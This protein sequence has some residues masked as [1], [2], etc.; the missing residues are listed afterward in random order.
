MN[1]LKISGGMPICGELAVGGAK[2]SSLPLLAATILGAGESVLHNCPALSDVDAACKI[3]SYL[4]C[5]VRRENSTVVVNTENLTHFDVPDELMREMRS[6]IV[7]LGA[8]A[9]RLGKTK[10]SFPGGCDL[11]ARPIDLHLSSLRQLGLQIREEH[12]YLN[13][14]AESRLKGCDISLSFPSVGA[15]ENIMLAAATAQGTTVI[16]N[17]AQEPE[18][19]DLADFLNKCGAKIQNAGKSTIIIEGVDRLSGA[20]HTVIPDRIVATTYL[21]CAAATGGEI[22]VT[23]ADPEAISSVLPV[24]R[25]MGCKILTWD[26]SIY[27]KGKQRLKGA[28]TIRTM[29]Y[30]GFPTDAQALLMAL[31]TR[32][33]GTTVF[34]ENIFENRFK[35]AGELCR[36]GADIKIEGK[37]AVVQGV[38]QLYGASVRATDLRGGA[39]MIIA[40]LAAQGDTTI[41]DVYHIERGYENI[42]ENL[43]KLGANIES[44]S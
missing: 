20:E 28:K 11:G 22:I 37:V 32:A 6:S 9:A 25:E 36:M 5:N 19:I 7:F 17:A 42:C 34:V 41:S 2:N 29:P 23:Q 31:A 30:P 15:T 21:C 12:G 35:H 3:L 33:D 10:I 38:K 1:K 14:S 8:I 24:M 44:I 13:C 16:S 4:G 18:I 26:H 43:S 27:L 39:A 40:G